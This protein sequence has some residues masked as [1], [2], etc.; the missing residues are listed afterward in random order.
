VAVD[1]QLLARADVDSCAVVFEPTL[2]AWG[3]PHDFLHDD[4]EVEKVRTVLEQ[5]RQQGH[6]AALL[7]TRDTT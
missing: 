1:G 2:R 5:A 4:S 6:P 3:M 7:I